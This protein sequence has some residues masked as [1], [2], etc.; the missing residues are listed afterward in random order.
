MSIDAMTRSFLRRVPAKFGRKGL[1]R[2][3]LYN[4]LRRLQAYG[5]VD[6][7][8]RPSTADQAVT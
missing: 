6:E 4:W 7:V 5:L 3:T 8:S 2:G 1:T